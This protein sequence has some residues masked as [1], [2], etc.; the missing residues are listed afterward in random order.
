MAGWSWD[1]WSSRPLVEAKVTSTTPIRGERRVSPECTRLLE[2]GRLP[3]TPGKS[4]TAVRSDHCFKVQESC[5][6]TPPA[7]CKMEVIATSSA[8]LPGGLSEMVRLSP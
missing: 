1:D 2:L 7:V 4:S 5:L 6:L 3:Q 8:G